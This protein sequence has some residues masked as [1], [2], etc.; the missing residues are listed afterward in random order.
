[1]TDGQVL[2]I[3]DLL[4]MDGRFQPKFVKRFASLE[5]VAVKAIQQYCDEVRREAFPNERHV[6]GEA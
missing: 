3:H 6:Y 2:V 5:E 1:V 4:G